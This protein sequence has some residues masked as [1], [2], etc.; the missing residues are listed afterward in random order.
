MKAGRPW[1]HPDDE[2]TSVVVRI[3]DAA[4]FVVVPLLGIAALVGIYLIVV[5]ALSLG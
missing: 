2:P 4:A 5:A 3:M 1:L